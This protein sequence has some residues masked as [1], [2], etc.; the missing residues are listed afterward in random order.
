MS[1]FRLVCQV[2]DIPKQG[3]KNINLD[4]VEIAIFDTTE[5][6]VARSGVCKH[7]AFKLELCEI[8]GDIVRCPLHGWSYHI[9]SGKGIRPSWTCLEHFALELRGSEIWIDPT[10]I[11]TTG[12]EFDTS[13]FQW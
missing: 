11:D 9:S 12:D 1:E 4:G 7:N 8:S 6:L 3:A 13:S 5:G 2:N 10:K